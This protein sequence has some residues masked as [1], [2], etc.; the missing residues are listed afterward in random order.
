MQDGKPGTTPA[1]GA[2]PDFGRAGDP[3]PPSPMNSPLS[4]EP[5]YRQLFESS[6]LPL[7]VYDLETLRFLDVNEV[8]CTKYGYSRAD[9]DF[10]LKRR[11]MALMLLHRASDPV[12]HICIEGWQEQ[13]DDLMQLQEL[14][15]PD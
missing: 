15:W 1:N 8:A 5:R 9:I 7:W 3:A 13:A 14:I 6:P 10:A 12:R 11:L 4:A 2:G